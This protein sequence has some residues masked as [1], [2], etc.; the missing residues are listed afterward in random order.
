M[1]RGLWLVLASV[2]AAIAAPAALADGDPA[3]DILPTESVS[4]PISSPSPD[5]QRML[6]SAVNVVYANGNRVK[7]AVMVA[8]DAAGNKSGAICVPLKVVKR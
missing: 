7:V 2:T 5:V 8:A 4:F 3:S 1:R 6:S